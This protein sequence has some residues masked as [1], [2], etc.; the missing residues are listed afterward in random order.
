MKRLAPFFISIRNNVFA[1]ILFIVLWGISSLFFPSYVIPSPLLVLSNGISYLQAEFW[2]QLFLTIYR[3]GAGF[4]CA[5][6]LGTLSGILAVGV[7]KAQYLNTLMVLFQV[8]PGTILGIIFLLVFGIG[9]SVPIALVAFLILPVI[10]INTSNALAKKNVLLEHYL[11]SIGG[12]RTHLVKNIYVPILIPTFQSNLTIGFSLSLK[13]VILGEFIGS[14]DG[15]G[16]LLNLSKIYF[17]MD[18]VFFYLFVILLMMVCFQIAMNVFF[19]I[20]LGK[21]FYPE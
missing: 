21:Y 18:E 9:S 10:S 3:V 20:F 12:K 16:Y 4:C 14:Q 7:N 5:L 2:Q 13:I 11:R 17:K 8:I 1:L 19:T 15:I 6:L